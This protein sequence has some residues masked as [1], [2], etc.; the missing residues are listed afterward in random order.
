MGTVAAMLAQARATL[1]LG[2]SPPG[3]NHNKIT[4]WYNANIARIGDGAWCDMGVT[5][6]AAHSGNLD[7]ILAG[8]GVGYAYTVWHAQRFQR[9]DRWHYGT[10]GIKPGDI[11]FFNWQRTR[12][13]GGIDHVGIVE[14][15]RGGTLYTIEANKGDKCVRVARDSTYVVGYGRPDYETPVSVM[16]PADPAKPATIRAPSGYP[17]LRRGSRSARVK[18]LQHGLLKAERQLPKYGADG[19][20]G[21]ETEKAVRSFQRAHHCTADGEYGP[22]TARALKKAIG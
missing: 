15:V 12:S 20:Y 22:Q 7:A 4:S 21:A 16:P 10:A 9:E 5:Y 14:K 2:E 3:S 17:L 11:V 19:D 13:V 6:W 8:K 1:G 18:Q